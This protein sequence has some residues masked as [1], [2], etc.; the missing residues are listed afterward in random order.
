MNQVKKSNNKLPDF[1]KPLFWSY[2]FSKINLQDDRERIVINTINYGDWEHWQWLIKYYG[3]AE[4]QKIIRNSPASEFRKRAFKLISLLLKIK[5]TKYE[6]RGVK[7]AAERN[8][9]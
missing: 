9:P 5:K 4:I 8:I 7:I 1:F 6:S 3:K 2:D